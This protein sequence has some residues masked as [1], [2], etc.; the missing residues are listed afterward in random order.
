MNYQAESPKNYQQ[1]CLCVLL[2]D[3]SGSMKKTITPDSTIQRIDKLNEGVCLF[4][5]DIINQRGGVKGSTTRGQ[6]E[7]S[8]IKFDQE[9]SIIRK[10]KLLEITEQPPILAERGSTTETVKAIE[11]ALEVINERK[12]FYDQTGQTYYRP[13]IVLITDGS[14]SSPQYEIDRIAEVLK[15]QIEH[16]HISMIGVSVLDTVNQSIMEKISGGHNVT[17]KDFRFAQF[18]HWLSNSFSIITKS[19]DDDN[20]DIS[21][22]KYDWM[23]NIPG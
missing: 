6:L 20:Y 19:N 13:W 4:F 11:K 16:K 10:P 3:V 9:P 2:L 23:K 21:H 18:F 1:K 7:V 8:I 14:P 17:L 15:E 5:D 12:R 22:G